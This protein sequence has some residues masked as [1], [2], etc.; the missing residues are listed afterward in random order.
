MC[1]SQCKLIRY[2]VQLNLMFLYLPHVWG[3]LVLNLIGGF[4]MSTIFDVFT[5]DE[6]LENDG[7]ILEYPDVHVT[8]AR[9]GGV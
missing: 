6:S 9:A 3:R 2:L 1:C 7:V 4:V 8:I 5:T